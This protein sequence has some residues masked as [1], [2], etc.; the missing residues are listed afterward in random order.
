MRK[1]IQPILIVIFLALFLG[2]S[3]LSGLV[4]EN[5]SE[6]KEN[7]INFWL[8]RSKVYEVMFFIGALIPLCKKTPLSIGLMWST[9]IV[10]GASVI[11]KCI[12]DFARYDLHDLIV[13]AGAMYVGAI[14][15]KNEKK[16]N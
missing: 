6:S 7:Y 9:A 14:K 12:I 13:G 15:Y 4:I 8:F 3:W 11:D 1:F 10:V 5:P 16:R 2:N